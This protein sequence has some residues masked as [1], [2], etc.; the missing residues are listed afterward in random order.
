MDSG[1]SKKVIYQV[2][3]ANVNRAREGLRVTEEVFR[4]VK[5]NTTVTK[6]LK[7]MRHAL[8]GI[9]AR[10]RIDRALLLDCRDSSRDPGRT[11]HTKREFTRRSPRDILMANMRRV[12]EALRVLEEFS[13]L[14]DASASRRFKQL[15]F[16]FYDVEKHAS[17][18]L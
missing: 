1:R 2:L 10:S 4:Y 16:R 12:G 7:D 8:Q 11:I 14:C 17:Q 13:K 6:E 5:K 3:D 18:A 9:M 15:R